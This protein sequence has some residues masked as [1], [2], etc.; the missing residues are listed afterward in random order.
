MY[1]NIKYINN[2]MRG[3]KMKKILIVVGHNN[4]QKGE[5]AK[6]LGEQEY[7]YWKSV[8]EKIVEKSNK[9]NLNVEMTLR[10]YKASYQKEMQKVVNLINENHYDIVFELHFNQYKPDK[11]VGGAECLVFHKSSSHNIAKSLLCKLQEEFGV[12]NRGLVLIKDKNERGGYGIVKSIAPYILVEPFFGSNDEEAQKFTDK[13]KVSN[14]FVE[15]LKG[16]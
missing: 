6:A 10:D 14:F 4:I 13:E 15:F 3:M 5:Y 9:Q 16:I 8:C 2:K 12:K 7:D 1:G 11:K